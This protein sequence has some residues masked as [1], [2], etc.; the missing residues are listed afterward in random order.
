MR[1]ERDTKF[2][3]GDTIYFYNRPCRKDD[4]R[5]G[6]VTSVEISAD[7]NCPGSSSLDYTIAVGYRCQVSEFSGEYV[8]ETCAF[9]TREEVLKELNQ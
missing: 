1:I 3:V 9:A 8:P 7:Q 5:I 6:V 4:V 2:N